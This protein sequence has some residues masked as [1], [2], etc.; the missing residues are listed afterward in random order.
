MSSPVT[1]A[2]AC[3]RLSPYI[4]FGAIS[5]RSIHHRLESARATIKGQRGDEAKAWRSAYNS[6]AKRLRWHCHFMQKLEDQ[7]DIEFHNM[8]RGFDGI[9]ENDWNESFFNAWRQGQTGYPIIDACMR[10]VA[11]TGW[12]TFR[13]RAMVV[14]FASYHLWLHWRQPAQWLARHFLDYECGIH[15]SQFQMQSG[16]TGINTLRIYSPIKQTTDQDPEGVFI[17][18]WVPELADLPSEYL[19]AP[20]DTP[21]LLQ[22]CYGV[23]IGEHYPMPIVDH[24][25]ATKAA[26]D[27]IYSLRKQ[28]DIR[29]MSQ[30]V[31]EKHGSRKRQPKRGSASRKR[32]STKANSD[33]DSD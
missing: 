1:A 13:M 7:P 14:S 16:V 15:F 28:P 10:C 25:I 6:L 30:A 23:T 4:S 29:E 33:N 11:Q 5:H 17:K 32:S 9:R 12:L 27:K 20:W 31:F 3:S 19:A 18:Q 26:R 24:A 2:D 22:Q 21:P 8:H